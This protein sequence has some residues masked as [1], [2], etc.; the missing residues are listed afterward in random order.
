M[1]F[2]SGFKGLILKHPDPSALRAVYGVGVPPFDSW[3]W[4]FESH[5]SLWVL[6]LVQ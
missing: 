3:H 1:G 4:G 2:N 6:S 5:C